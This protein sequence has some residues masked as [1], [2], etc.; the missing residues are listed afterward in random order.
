MC[1]FCGVET[2][3]SGDC[4]G[5]AVFTTST[6]GIDEMTG[7]FRGAGPFFPTA[8]FSEGSCFTSSSSPDP[9]LSSSRSITIL[10]AEEEEERSR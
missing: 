2:S 6:N 3:S 10:T 1:D 9:S 5:G 8:S 7:F 4:D